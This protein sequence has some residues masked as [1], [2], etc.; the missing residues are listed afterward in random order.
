MKPT[1]E[2]YMQQAIQLAK[3]GMGHTSPNPM[4]GC[5]VVKNNEIIATGYHER[6][7]EYHAERHKAGYYRS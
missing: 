1:K 6:Y 7:G 4:V 2:Y 5:V 3:Q